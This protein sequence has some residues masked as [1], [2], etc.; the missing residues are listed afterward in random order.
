MQNWECNRNNA[1]LTV[2]TAG[3][4][5][6]PGFVKALTTK[7]LELGSCLRL[8]TE[9]QSDVE[10]KATT[11]TMTASEAAA[12]AIKITSLRYHRPRSCNIS[13]C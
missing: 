4:L 7:E 3:D 5:G 8:T 2:A 6:A 12:M 9:R 13:H 10:A 1:T 11:S